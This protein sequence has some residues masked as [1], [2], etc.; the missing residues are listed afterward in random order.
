MEIIET[1][2]LIIVWLITVVWMYG[3]RVRP[4]VVTTSLVS[5]SVL[6]VTLFFTLTD[7]SRYHLLWAIPVTMFV[8]TH[9]FVFITVHVPVLNTIVITIGKLYTE[10]LRVG[11]S[12]TKRVQLQQEFEINMRSM[13]NDLAAKKQKEFKQKKQE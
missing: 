4:I 3:V 11:I 5:L 12:K 9:I 7:F 6:L 1:I 2:I 13:L 10:I 8:G